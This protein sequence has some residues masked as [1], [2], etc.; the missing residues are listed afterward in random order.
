MIGEKKT[1]RLEKKD[2]SGYGRGRKK[3]EEED[4]IR[5]FPERKKATSGR[6]KEEK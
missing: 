1:Q 3:E 4:T 2:I 5:G 6:D